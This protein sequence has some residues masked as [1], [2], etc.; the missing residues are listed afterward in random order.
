[1]IKICQPFINEEWN[2]ELA[3]KQLVTD[4]ERDLNILL[5]LYYLR[6]GFSH[7]DVYLVSPLSKLGFMALQSL[8][9][10]QTHAD[11]DYARSTLFLAL[12]G[13][14]EQGCSFYIS[15]TM[16]YILRQQLRPEEV[17]YL[18]GTED[19]ECAADERPGM[20]G[21]IQSAWTPAIVNTSDGRTAQGLSELA[22]EFLGTGTRQTG[23]RYN[24]DGSPVS[25]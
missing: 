9:T 3:A 20:A 25:I 4:A 21:E 12:Q 18:A 22:S 7:A 8:S 17:R 24:S 1:M 6:H 10:S 16:Y 5:R 14:R 23:E 2:Y 15:R 11:L 19:A 13:L